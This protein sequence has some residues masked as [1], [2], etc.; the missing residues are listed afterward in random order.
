MVRTKESKRGVN[1]RA[2]KY[3][4]RG[5]HTLSDWKWLKL[6]FGYRCLK[7]L[8]PQ[9]NDV[10]LSIDHIVPLARGGTNDLSNIQPLCGRCNVEKDQEIIDYRAT[11]EYRLEKAYKL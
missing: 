7:C 2:K 5:K 9:S 3:G 10:K 4:A 6:K 8:R 11:F 1:K